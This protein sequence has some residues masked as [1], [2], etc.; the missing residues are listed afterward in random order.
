MNELYFWIGLVVVN[1]TLGVLWIA[2]GYMGKFVWDRI[3]RIYS[4]TVITYWLDRLEREGL[5]TFEKARKGEQ[6]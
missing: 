6:E 2:T 1:V 5:R 4:L 3:T